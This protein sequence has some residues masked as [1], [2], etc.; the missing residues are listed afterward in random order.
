MTEEFE[1]ISHKRMKD[2]NLFINRIIY[3]SFHIHSDI[4]FLFVMEGKGTCKT[5]QKIHRLEPGTVLL[6]NSNEPHD[7]KGT[8]GEIVILILQISP[9]FL[10]RYFRGLENVYFL[11]NHLNCILAPEVTDKLWKDMLDI[12]A[13]YIMQSECYELNLISGLTYLLKK[14]YLEVPHQNIN[15]VEYHKRK[16][17]THRMVRIDKYI[18]EH[19]QEPIRLQTLADMEGISVTHFS[20]FFTES[21]GVTFQEFLNRI[22][23]EHAIRTM[24]NPALS[25]R[26]ICYL[27]GFSDYRYMEKVFQSQMGVSP[28]VFRKELRAHGTAPQNN[29]ERLEYFLTDEEAMEEIIA[30]R[31]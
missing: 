31:R 24:V 21:F 12:A 9:F 28:E 10:E 19:Y 20:H 29:T 8:D 25:L 17:R 3:R 7:I 2:I 11:E 4:E 6:I 13:D 15:S 26:D 23:L 30:L 14:L 1:V 22:R 5:E 18:E 16:K 27:S